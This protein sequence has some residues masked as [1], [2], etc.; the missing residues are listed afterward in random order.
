MKKSIITSF[1]LLLAVFYAFGTVTAAACTLDISLINQDPYPAIPGDYVK[2]VFEI[3]GLENP[4]CGTVTFG[5]KE[6][7]PKTFSQLAEIC[8]KN[9]MLS[10]RLKNSAAEIIT[11]GF[12]D[13][14]LLDNLELFLSQKSDE[15]LVNIDYIDMRFPSMVITGTDG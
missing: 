6:D 9:D 14:E 5:I 2:V 13:K 15:L 1:I 11:D 10:I 4:N 8:S 3:D 12:I 7:Y